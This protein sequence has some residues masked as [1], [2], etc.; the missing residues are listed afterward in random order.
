MAIQHGIP[1][2]VMAESPASPAPTPVAA[3]LAGET[4]TRPVAVFV[5][6]GMGEQVPFESIDAVAS[7]I[8]AFPTAQPPIRTSMHQHGNDRVPRAEMEFVGADGKPRQVHIFEAY[9]APLTAGKVSIAEVFW[10]LMRSGC[11]GFDKTYTVF[12]R[13]MFGR[14]RAFPASMAATLKHALAY[15][16]LMGVLASLGVMSAIAL[17]VGAARA[18]THGASNWP[19]TYLLADLTFDFAAYGVVAL[20][21]ALFYALAWL[22]QR[23][24]KASWK[25]PRYAGLWMWQV[26]LY[27]MFTLAATIFTGVSVLL[28]LALHQNNLPYTVWS[29]WCPQGVAWL[30]ESRD[31]L[32]SGIV[33]AVWALVLVLNNRARKLVVDYLGDVLA[34]VAPHTDNKFCETRQAIQ[35]RA[36]EAAR[37]IYEMREK[38]G[39][40]SYQRVI[41]LA[42]SLGSVIAYDTLNALMLD[43][44]LN[45]SQLQ[46]LER[47]SHLISFG[48]PLDLTA[49]IYREQRHQ[50]WIRESLAAN[51][52]PLILDPQYRTNLEWINIWSPMDPISS[53]LDYY[54]APGRPVQNFHDAGCN[55]PLLAHTMY[56]QGKVLSDQLFAAL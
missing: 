43:D 23:R 8:S 33:A 37:A 11:S 36:I 26:R 40:F 31:A 20:A 14:P 41:F 46:V 6:H 22:M 44:A 51:M 7:I 25:R 18:L 16:V 19:S 54:N 4:G 35:R 10:F 27:L 53:R 9:W 52:Q 3:A 1:N 38:N 32:A 45:V 29:Y 5:C 42:H 21:L 56:W 28:Q 48:S 30:L 2:A 24:V 47:T 12:R 13:Y 55:I 49:F 39:D 34:Y 15:L 17:A 50:L